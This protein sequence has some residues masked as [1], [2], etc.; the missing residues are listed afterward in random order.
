VSTI[1]L[2]ET[3]QVR[4]QWDQNKVARFFNN[5]D[6]VLTDSGDTATYWPKFR[7]RR[8]AEGNETVTSC[9]GLKMMPLTKYTRETYLGKIK[10]VSQG[11]RQKHRLQLKF[12]VGWYLRFTP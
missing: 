1:Q 5:V 6:V 2:F 11:E 8:N 7:Q 9:N 3:Q 4:S 10:T 12:A